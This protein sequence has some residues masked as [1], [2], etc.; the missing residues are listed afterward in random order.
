MKLLKQ[1]LTINVT[2]PSLL[3]P[4]ANKVVY[5][6]KKTFKKWGVW[7]QVEWNKFI[8]VDEPVRDKSSPMETNIIP[9]D[10]K[11][12]LLWPVLDYCVMKCVQKVNNE[13]CVVGP[14]MEW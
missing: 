5:A 14:R 3:Y 2:H 8:M 6:L 11:L 10:N 12:G 1:N 7:W 13:G 4:L 9:D